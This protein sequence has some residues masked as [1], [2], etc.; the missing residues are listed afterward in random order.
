MN[1]IKKQSV[2]DILDRKAQDFRKLGVHADETPVRIR[3][4]EDVRRYGKENIQG[5]SMLYILTAAERHTDI[6]SAH[7][8]SV[9][10][11][12][13][14]L[15]LGKQR[16]KGTLL[17]SGFLQ[18]FQILRKNAPGLENGFDGLG[19]NEPGAVLLIRVAPYP[20]LR[21]RIHAL[22]TERRASD[23]TSGIEGVDQFRRVRLIEKQPGNIHTKPRCFFFYYSTGKFS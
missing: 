21:R 5:E 16:G 10:Y 23:L 12:K 11:D 7:G 2:F 1:I 8:E 22:T 13:F 9:D 19:F 15:P 6:V 20:Q 3:N 4:T 17:P 14:L 18:Y